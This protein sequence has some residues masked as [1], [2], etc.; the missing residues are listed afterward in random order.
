[1]P[2]EET[3]R[4]YRNCVSRYSYYKSSMIYNNKKIDKISY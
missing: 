4:F 3:Q 1:M 2:H